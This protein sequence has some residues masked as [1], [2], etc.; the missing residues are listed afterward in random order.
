MLLIVIFYWRNWSTKHHNLPIIT[1]WQMEQQEPYL[2]PINYIFLNYEC[3][4]VWINVM[5]PILSM[6]FYSS[7]I[8]FSPH[9]IEEIEQ[10]KEDIK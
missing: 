1:L 7:G 4:V 8:I 9:G 6:A 10:N 3:L 5:V 2:L